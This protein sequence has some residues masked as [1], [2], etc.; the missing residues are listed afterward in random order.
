MR[1]PGRIVRRLPVE[2]WVCAAVA[3][4]NAISWSLITPPFQVPDEPDHIAYVQQLA[5][6]GSLPVASGARYSREETAALEG[7]DFEQIVMFPGKIATISTRAQ[8]HQLQ[9]GLL[10]AERNTAPQ[11]E[12]AGVA[13]GEPPLYYALEVIPYE[14]GSS[15]SLL[16]RL[17]LMRLFSA[18]MGGLTALFVYLFLREALPAVRWSWLV[19]GLGVA[20][21]PLLGVMSG[22]VNPDA[23][24]Y[25]VSAALFYCLARAFRRGLTP[26]SAAV[27]GAV[28]AAG[29]LTKLNF[30]GLLPGVLVGLLILGARL[31]RSSRR[32][33]L[34]SLAFAVA[35]SAGPV[36]LYVLSNLLAGRG[37]FGA[38]SG[39][40]SKSSHHGSL[41]GELSYIW[42]MYLPRLPGMGHDFA[43]IFMARQLWFNG[44]VGSYGWLE[45]D[46]P[47]WVYT[48]ALI[49]AGLIAGLAVFGAYA[50]RTTLRARLSELGVYALMT[51]GLMGLIG[52]D[53]Y[54]LFPVNVGT[55]AEARYLLPL[56]VLWGAV[57]AL[58]AR[59]A[60]RRWGPVVGALILVLA[61]AHD[62]FSQLLV[63]SRY[64]V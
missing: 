48:I 12:S 4:L 5:E 17:A 18:L 19:G 44:L 38:L 37:A 7:L 21:F 27:I 23:L 25:A 24:L 28:L 40:V 54:L 62:I 32:S 6:T 31:A 13:A 11:R 47:G 30:L 46:F 45:T 43:G 29:L 61:F 55:Y 50:A 59:G 51:I 64:Y 35:C 52:A 10:K 58:A 16:D 34:V 20:F 1:L 60:G 56:L 15:G 9:A 41:P 63:I 14:L 33:A 3:C 42:Q 39:A 57:L 2:A 53:G 26:R 49:P 36:G 22:S 8:Q